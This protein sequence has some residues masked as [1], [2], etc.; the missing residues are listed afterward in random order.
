M[1]F[2]RARKNMA[3]TAQTMWVIFPIDFSRANFVS[4]TS[5]FNVNCKYF[6]D[7]FLID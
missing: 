7:T 3:A 6:Y 4:F 5:N 2:F 1:I